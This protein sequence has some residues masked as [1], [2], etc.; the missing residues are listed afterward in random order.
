MCY[1]IPILTVPSVFDAK[2][3]KITERPRKNCIPSFIHSHRL[4]LVPAVP[5]VCERLRDVNVPFSGRRESE[6]CVKA[7]SGHDRFVN[8]EHNQQQ[9]RRLQH[10]PQHV[11]QP[12]VIQP[13]MHYAPTPNPT[14]HPPQFTYHQARSPNHVQQQQIQGGAK[15]REKDCFDLIHN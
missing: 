15:N 9:Q 5:P 3:N 10:R 1:S 14:P 2:V 4:Q 8:Q 6:Q 7:E 13:P 11:P 12:Q